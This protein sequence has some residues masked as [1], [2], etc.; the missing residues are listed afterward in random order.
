MISKVCFDDCCTQLEDMLYHKPAW[1][2]QNRKDWLL[3]LPFKLKLKIDPQLPPID[4]TKQ[5]LAQY[6]AQPFYRQWYW[7]WFYSFGRVKQLQQGYRLIGHLKQ[8]MGNQSALISLA[9][10]LKKLASSL[11]PWNWLYGVVKMLNK[12]TIQHE[13]KKKQAVIKHLKEIVQ[14]SLDDLKGY[15]DSVVGTYDLFWTNQQEVKSLG[16]LDVKTCE[17]KRYELA[18]RVRD[19]KDESKHAWINYK[20]CSKKSALVYYML[21]KNVLTKL[22]EQLD[23]DQQIYSYKKSYPQEEIIKNDEVRY[24]TL[25]DLMA[26]LREGILLGSAASSDRFLWGIF[27]KLSQQIIVCVENKEHKFSIKSFTTWYFSLI[28]LAKRL[29]S[30]LAYKSSLISKKIQPIDTIC[31]EG[32]IM[33][34]AVQ[35]D[36]FIQLLPSLRQF[37]IKKQD[38]YAKLRNC[39]ERVSAQNEDL[40]KLDSQLVANLEKLQE[41]LNKKINFS[42]GVGQGFFNF[43]LGL[44]DNLPWDELNEQLKVYR[45]KLGYEKLECP[46]EVFSH[47]MKVF[48]DYNR[49]RHSITLKCL[50]TIHNEKISFETKKSHLSVNEQKGLTEPLIEWLY[51]EVANIEIRKIKAN[52]IND[53]KR[54]DKAWS[55]RKELVLS[56]KRLE[57]VEKARHYVEKLEKESKKEIV[58]SSRQYHPDKIPMVEQTKAGWMFHA[59][60]QTIKNEFEAVQNEVLSCS[61]FLSP[62]HERHVQLIKGRVDDLQRAL[63]I[64]SKLGMSCL[65]VELLLKRETKRLE[66]LTGS[67]EQIRKYYKGKFF[68]LE[69]K[70]LNLPDKMIEQG[71]FIAMMLG[72]LQMRITKLEGPSYLVKENHESLERRIVFLEKQCGIAHRTYEEN[73]KNDKDKLYEAEPSSDYQDE[74]LDSISRQTLAIESR[75][76]E[77]ES[78]IALVEENKDKFDMASHST[79]S[80]YLHF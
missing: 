21:L 1:G 74:K 72:M 79:P 40:K 31:D 23:H 19:E 11:Y 32:R 22:R 27:E 29:E 18:N 5:L 14:R 57:G 30:L 36:Q 55:E 12:K 51:S 15:A 9:I 63:D 64:F 65:V 20:N 37:L 54:I 45:D 33:D 58:E 76:R 53:I 39:K 70:Y 16:L 49:K 68:G 80:C 44:E 77:W 6:H 41:W 38:E 62:I 71:L 25:Q 56:K 3:A 48:T 42:Y 2:Y 34:E 24:K 50:N 26:V 46:I 61:K 69:Q 67:K 35:V 43:D 52:F 73:N 4:Q 47:T 17:A 66:V 78:R 59:I 28:P 75:V 60:R 8:A 10:S 7:Y 13:I